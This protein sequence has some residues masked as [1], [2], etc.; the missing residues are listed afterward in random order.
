MRTPEKHNNYRVPV[1]CEMK[2]ETERNKM[3][4]NEVYRNKT[5]QNET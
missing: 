5:E 1:K 2:R 3:K 4:R